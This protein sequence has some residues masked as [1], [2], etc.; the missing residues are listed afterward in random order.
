MLK[1]YMNC[2]GPDP[3]CEPNIVFQ[4]KTKQAHKREARSAQVLC[5]Y[6][7]FRGR[8]TA[9]GSTIQAVDIYWPMKSIACCFDTV[10]GCK[11]VHIITLCVSTE[12]LSKH[13]F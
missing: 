12:T 5:M 13:D 1:C 3:S 11:T 7:K 4:I 10:T 9:R 2:N 6:V 8:L